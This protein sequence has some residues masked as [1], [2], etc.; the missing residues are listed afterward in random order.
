V[1]YSCDSFTL[2]NCTVMNSAADVG[3]GGVVYSEERTSVLNCTI[4]N[5]YVTLYIIIY[6]W[7]GSNQEQC[8]ALTH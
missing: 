4:I 3:Y 8:T 5:N 6:L 7:Q 2:T 1:I